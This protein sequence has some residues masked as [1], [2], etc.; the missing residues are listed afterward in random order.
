MCRY[1]REEIHEKVAA[2]NKVD[3]REH[4]PLEHVKEL[5]IVGL[6]EERLL[7]RFYMDGGKELP[8]YQ[9]LWVWEKGDWNMIEPCLFIGFNTAN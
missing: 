4:V 1:G 3:Y 7:I 8:I 2:Y 6:D 5:E 9:T